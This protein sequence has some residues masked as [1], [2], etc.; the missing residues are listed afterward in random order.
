[1]KRQL[2]R[3]GIGGFFC[4]ALLFTACESESFNERESKNTTRI[5]VKTLSLEELENQFQIMEKLETILPGFRT[6]SPFAGEHDF[7]INTDEIVY[8]EKGNR[9]SYTFSIIRKEITPGLENLILNYEQ[10]DYTAYQIRY[11]FTAAQLAHPDNLESKQTRVTITLFDPESSVTDRKR[12]TPCVTWEKRPV[13]WNEQGQETHSEWVKVIDQDCMDQLNSGGQTSNS[14]TSGG[15]SSGATS[16]GGTPKGGVPNGGWGGWLGTGVNTGVYDPPPAGNQGNNAVEN[17]AGHTGSTGHTTN[18]PNSP[19]PKADESTS[20]TEAGG[21]TVFTKPV[22]NLRFALYIKKFK[23]SVKTVVPNSLWW[24]TTNGKKISEYLKQHFDNQTGLIDIKA[25]EFAVWA[26]DYLINHPSVSVEHLLY[27]RVEINTD[28]G[29]FDNNDIGN[30]DNTAYNDFNPQQDVWPNIPSVIP[31]NEFVGWGAP[32]VNRNCMDYAKAQIAKKGYK[33]SNY[34]DL[35]QTFQIYTEQKGVNHEQL[36][37][38]L[39]YLKYALSKGIPVIVGIDN[40]EG[41]PGN[42]DQTTDHFIV[43]VGMGS[44]VKGKYLQFYDNASGDSSFG[45]SPLNLLYYNVLNGIISGSSQTS[46]AQ[47]SQLHEYIVTHIRKSK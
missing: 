35:G 19:F 3:L 16:N 42:P 6:A 9:H 13:G 23:E 46:Y 47:S 2:R 11:D 45:S 10:G 24:R 36:S 18:V 12:P 21:V 4:F 40:H 30:Y 8:I 17:P 26:I 14:A 15:T 31:I 38:G 34:Y 1:M 29:D 43:I 28:I 27:N 41:S 7:T 5:V 20:I 37:K 39:S 25:S 44:D 33:I 22:F 32:N